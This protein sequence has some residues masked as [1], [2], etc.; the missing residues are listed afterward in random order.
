MRLSGGRFSFRRAFVGE[1]RLDDSGF[2]VEDA[3][4][5]G[6]SGGDAEGHFF[7]GAAGVDGVV[8]AEDEELA[9]VLRGWG[10]DAEVVA[11]MFLGDAFDVEAVLAQFGGDD[12]AAAV[13]GGFFEA[14]G[15]GEDE[16]AESG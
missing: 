1:E 12:G 7:Q 9:V 6:F 16:A 3:W 11:A 8:V 2:H 15:F 14:G 13:G 5:V 10:D 4:A